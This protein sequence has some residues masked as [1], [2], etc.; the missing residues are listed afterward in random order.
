MTG[1]GAKANPLFSPLDDVRGSGTG[2]VRV[3]PTKVKA[4]LSEFEI[5]I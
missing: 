4:C 1:H 5:K 3:G 2:L